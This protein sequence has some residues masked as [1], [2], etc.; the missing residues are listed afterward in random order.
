MFVLELIMV[1]GFTF[2][3]KLPFIIY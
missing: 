1:L 2:C 3:F